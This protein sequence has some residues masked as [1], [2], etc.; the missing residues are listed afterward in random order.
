MHIYNDIVF[1]KNIS[2]N[3]EDVMK[4]NDREELKKWKILIASELGSINGRLEKMICDHKMGHTTDHK[5]FQ[6]IK[7]YKRTQGLL[8]QQIQHRLSELKEV[9]KKENIKHSITEEYT[10]ILF[11]KNKVMYLAPN[12]MNEYLQELYDMKDRLKKD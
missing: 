6:K 12:R 9:K 10:E 2:I 7:G 3:T 4:S 5:G 1:N 8:C 11:W